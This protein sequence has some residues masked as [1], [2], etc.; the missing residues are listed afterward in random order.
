MGG[1]EKIEEKEEGRGG[2][3]EGE[4]GR[5]KG[6]EKGNKPP[7]GRACSGKETRRLVVLTE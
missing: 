6:K 2:E 4:R 1:E 3:G 7:A 5:G